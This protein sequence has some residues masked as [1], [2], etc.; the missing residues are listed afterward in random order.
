[1]TDTE[2]PTWS[3]IAGWYD[4]LLE[5]GS[6]PHETA[7]ATLL[8]LVPPLAGLTVLDIA[9]GTGIATRALVAG[10]AV[11]TGTDAS[12]AMIDLARSHGGGVA[13]VV[14]DAQ[15]LS[16]FA[17]ASIDGV[18]C[19]LGLMDIPDL[20]AVLAAVQRVLRPG[21]WFAFVIGHPCFLAPGAHPTTGPDGR[22]AVLVPE[23]LDERFWRSTNPN[24]V[25]RAGS[26]HRT[27][28]TYLNALVAAG[29]ALEEVVEPRASERL[30]AQQPV[31]ASVPIFLAARVRTA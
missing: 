23:Y 21:G 25:R 9:C 2:G 8:G 3:E 7:V 17:D 31:Y 29:F 10:G 16:T 5:G 20:G 13:Y 22:P 18:T 14:D 1:M 19:Q 27:V 11:A 30:A 24:G 4:E 12:S 28:G 6:G 26:H 15:T